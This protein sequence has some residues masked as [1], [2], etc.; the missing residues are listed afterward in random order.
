MTNKSTECNGKPTLCS[1]HNKNES[2]DRD[3]TEYQWDTESN[4]IANWKKTGLSTEDNYGRR[5]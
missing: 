3:N 1:T 5:D 4:K 2:K